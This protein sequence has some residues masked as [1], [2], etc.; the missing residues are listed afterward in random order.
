M[1]SKGMDA[2]QGYFKARSAAK[3][4]TNEVQSGGRDPGVSGPGTGLGQSPA[5]SKFSRAFSLFV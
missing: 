3:D 5:R 2:L 1:H 4:H